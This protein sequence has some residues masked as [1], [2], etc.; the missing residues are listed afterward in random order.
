MHS[1]VLTTL[2]LSAPLNVTDHDWLSIDGRH[3]LA[4]RPMSGR[5]AGVVWYASIRG[6]GSAKEA[7]AF[8]GEYSLS[9]RQVRL[10]L[11]RCWKSFGSGVGE[12]MLWAMTNYRQ[13]SDSKEDLYAIE[14]ELDEGSDG[15]VATAV[16]AAWINESGANV[17]GDRESAQFATAHIAVGSIFDL[18]PTERFP[19][20][21]NTPP[22]FVT[23]DR[24]LNRAAEG[25]TSVSATWLLAGELYG[26]QLSSSKGLPTNAVYAV[27]SLAPG[28]RWDSGSAW[29]LTAYKASS[30]ISFGALKGTFSIYNN[31]LAR[32]DILLL[33]LNVF[34]CYNGTSTG[35]R[36]RWSLRTDEESVAILFTLP[37]E[38]HV[39][40]EYMNPS[41]TRMDYID[42]SG[43]V[44]AKY[45]RNGIFSLPS[46]DFPYA[47]G[48]HDVDDSYFLR[49]GRPIQS[50]Q[51]LQRDE[52]A[53]LKYL[54]TTPPPGFRFRQ[55]ESPHTVAR[56]PITG[57]PN[58]AT[59]AETAWNTAQ[60]HY[61]QGEYAL[62]AKYCSDV[63]RL[64]PNNHFAYNG[65]A[66]LRATCPDGAQRDGKE[67]ISL[68]TKA[69]ELTE[70]KQGWILDT[71]AAA[72]AENGEFDK[73]V[74]WQKQA[75]LLAEDK[76][77]EKLRERLLLFESGRPY[78]E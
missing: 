19:L 40:P 17:G 32:Q 39:V 35:E 46:R 52:S 74:R 75:V 2:L 73:A 12:R 11:T 5:N 50:P 60:R 72:Y 1:L 15:I 62:A 20:G 26:W 43:K 69:C 4:F 9:D 13:Q 8:S 3:F 23:R 37:L 45:S 51:R 14:M 67:A 47:I 56:V 41:I 53:F 68:A 65:L 55:L 33:S 59:A 70:Y 44:I 18:L 57:S 71:L 7:L 49:A 30:G 42:S 16:K 31:H 58:A 34:R 48:D 66:W 54:T 76:L 25:A 77:K 22:G 28:D 27:L 24:W 63:I 61:K 64:T 29:L 21:D 36:I 10:A 38:D 6:S 78:R